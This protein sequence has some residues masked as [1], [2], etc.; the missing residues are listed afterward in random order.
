MA[1]LNSTIQRTLPITG[2]TCA[3]CVATVE[4][5][6]KKVPGVQNALVNLSSERATVEFDPGRTSLAPIL[7]RIRR[8]GYGVAAGE[9]EVL[10]Q[11]L[12]DDNDAHRLEKRLGAM[13]GVLSAA[14]NIVN[15]KVSVHYIPTIVSQAEIRRSIVAGGYRLLGAQGEVE[16]TE[17]QARQ[18]EI[19]SQR[20]FLTIGVLLTLPLFLLSMARD[21]NLIPHAIG[22]SSWLSFLLFALA[23]PVQFYVGWQ[24]YRGAFNALRNK[25]ANMDVLIAMGS[26]AA[27]FYSIPVMLGWIPGHVYFETAAVIITLIRLGKYLEAQAK[28]ETSA[29]IKKLLGLKPRIARV[30]RAGQEMEIPV[31][32]V[33]IGDEVI[34]RPGERL[35][36][37]GIVIGGRSA[38]DE[39]LLTGESLPVEKSPG[40]KV[41][42]ASI[43]RLGSF[44]FEAT[45]VGKDTVLAQIVRLVE[46]AQ[47]S[48][49]PIQALADRVSAVFVPAVLLVALIT[50]SVWYW[51]IP[52]DAGSE[53]SL[54]A[55]ALINTVAVLVI[56][57]PCA[58]GLA[59]PTAVM[60]GAGR[61]AQSGILFKS[62]GALEQ[63]GRITS[64]I[65]DKTGTLT[66]GQ[67]ALTDLVVAPEDPGEVPAR[68]R[69]DAILH[70]AASLEQ[71]SEH[72]LGEAIV[73][74]AGN[75][76]LILSPVYGFESFTGEG[77]AGEVDG[78]RILVGNRRLFDRL[79]IDLSSWNPR[80]QTLESQGKSVVIIS[81]DG[82]PSALVGIA[83]ILKESS[84]RAIEQLQDMDLDVTMMTGD[85]IRSAQAIAEQ[86]GINN[87]LAEVLPGEKSEA[88]KS[89]QADGA[90][91]AMV[92]DGINDSPA[93]AQAQVG[94]AI[95]NGTDIAIAA[96]PIVLMS[97]DL[98]GV[99]RLIK[100][101]RLTLKVIKQNLFWAFIYNILLIPAAAA[102]LLNPLL[103]AA[104]MAFSSLF[105]DSNSLRLNKIKLG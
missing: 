36:V 40:D 86:A 16:D 41:I 30:V 77:V 43:N 93:L 33:E 88:V 4:R 13:E 35:P 83:D 84:A 59:T 37:D 22:H 63:A 57:C 23:T 29:A 82:K 79:G 48:K 90:V 94:I 21:L 58:M 100:L 42:G 56:A 81:V 15:E 96:A 102:G 24:Y 73:A 64:I 87:V 38:V 45:R 3:N 78:V 65:L 66:R 49:A 39:S 92:G 47:G 19:D 9:A 20:R 68:E 10:L 67:P 12:G 101:S 17:R 53:I 85:N 50:F 5:N 91:V 99:P 6:I 54:F 105:V 55:R 98:L 14:V 8:A 97:G 26:S 80:F 51:L 31:D 61:G 1:E 60:V 2:M 52:L 104:A 72:P 75:R 46:D 70:L 103:A 32:S 69:E 89:L 71:S 7:E 62:G 44:R 18:R 95:G 76:G 11:G 28:G 25:T 34:V 74:E 27:Y